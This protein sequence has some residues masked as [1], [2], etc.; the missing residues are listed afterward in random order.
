MA[1]EIAEICNAAV[2]LA[3]GQDVPLEA[4]PLL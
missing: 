2:R 1:E 3:L 4:S